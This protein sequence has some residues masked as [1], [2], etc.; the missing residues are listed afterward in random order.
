MRY[1]NNQNVR[2]TI[3]QKN[4]AATYRQAPGAQKGSFTMSNRFTVDFINKKIEGT[5][6]SLNKAKCYGSDEYRELCELM[7]AHPRFRVVTKKVKES[8]S[9]QTYKN[10]NFAFI[11]K[12]I[13]IQND[14][15]KIMQEYNAVKRTSESL[16]MGTYPYVKSWFLK[17]FSSEERPFSMEEAREQ[18]MNANAALAAARARAAA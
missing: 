5:K 1:T 15:D 11:E 13:S 18:I 4:R 3:P 9:K 8:T 2:E 6:A 14:S 7:E 17:R 16:G 10:L 12:Y